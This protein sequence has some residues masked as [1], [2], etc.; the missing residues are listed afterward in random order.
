TIVVFA[1]DNGGLSAHARGGDK[2]MHNLPLRS[3]KRSAYEGGLRVPFAIRWPTHIQA[4]T[5]DN[6]PIQLE[7]VMPT[8]CDLV[9]INHACAD[10]RSFADGLLGKPQIA[11]PL[12]FHHPH[13]W[14]A[15][16]PGIEPFSA[17]RHGDLKYIW[18]YDEAR[19]ELYDVVN[20][21]GETN[22]LV[23][24]RTADAQRLRQMLRE[25]LHDCN[26]QVPTREDG[27]VIVRP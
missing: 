11:H 17:V 10:G 8:L 23:A 4:D 19:E 22:N 2:H 12:Y 18:F 21:V 24:S 27:S 6:L 25:H 13:Y 1:S 26:A 14:G 5:I 20:D 7:D 16:G 15:T 9:D 3:G